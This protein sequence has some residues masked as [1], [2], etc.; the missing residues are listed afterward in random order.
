MLDQ[1]DADDKILGV[2]DNDPL[3]AEFHGLRE[4][5]NH[6]LREV[7]HFFTHYKDLEGKRVEPMGWEGRAVAY[8]RITHAQELYQA[9]FK[10]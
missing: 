7:E 9:H 8:E 5:P 3:Y 6:Y 4:V 1:G 2:V 10:K